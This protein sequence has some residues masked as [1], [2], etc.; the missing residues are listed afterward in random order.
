MLIVTCRSR[1]PSTAKCARPTLQEYEQEPLC[2]AMGRSAQC[3]TGRKALCRKIR[4]PT[5]AKRRQNRPNHQLTL[6]ICRCCASNMPPYTSAKW[7]MKNLK[8]RLHPPARPAPTNVP[9]DPQTP[10]APLGILGV[11]RRASPAQFAVTR[12]LLYCSQPLRLHRFQRPR[13]TAASTPAAQHARPCSLPAPSEALPAIFSL[14]LCIQ[15]GRSKRRA[16]VQL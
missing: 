2:E 14:R 6:E 8:E 16:P 5:S 7:P 15:T 4:R 3:E 1:R 11:R 12:P 10:Y 9:A 13:P